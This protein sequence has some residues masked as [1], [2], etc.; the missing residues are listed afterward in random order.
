[1]AYSRL[2]TQHKTELL[3]KYYS[4]KLYY[5]LLNI[6]K[7]QKLLEVLKWLQHQPYEISRKDRHEIHLGNIPVEIKQKE[8]ISAVP[9]DCPF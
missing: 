1:V 6:G 4:S 8:N 5:S 7:K 9:N 3:K 2:D